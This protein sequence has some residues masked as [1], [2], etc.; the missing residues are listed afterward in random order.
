[1][2]LARLRWSDVAGKIDDFVKH[3]D[4][5]SV[6]NRKIRLAWVSTYN[7]RCGL[8]THSEHL[9]EHFDR[10]IFDITVIGNHQEPLKPDPENVVRLWPDRSGSLA[11]VRDFIGNFDAVFVNFHFSLMEIHDLAALLKAAQLAGIDT[12]V[13]LHKTVDTVIAGR[14]VS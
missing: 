14:V 2:D 9:L 12:F 1:M 3:L 8:A 5:R 13:T 4:H 10:E 7:S 11:S 6:M